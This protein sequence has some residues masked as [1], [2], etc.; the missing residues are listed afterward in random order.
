MTSLFG[1]PLVWKQDIMITLVRFARSHR[2]GAAVAAL[3]SEYLAFDQKRREARPYLQAFAGFAILVLA[4]GAI[5]AVPRVES[6]EAAGVLI[7]PVCA[8]VLLNAWRWSRL[9]HRLV[10]IRAEIRQSAL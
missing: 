8:L 5:G 9:Q 3:M 1:C 4:G 2:S 7:L 6:I 10:A